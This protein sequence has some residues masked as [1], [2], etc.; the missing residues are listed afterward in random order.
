MQVTKDSPKQ[1][2]QRTEAGAESVVSSEKQEEQRELFQVRDQVEISKEGYVMQQAAMPQGKVLSLPKE[3]IPG[4]AAYKNA[5]K[6]AEI[7]EPLAARENTG[8]SIQ[9]RQT[10]AGIAQGK[11]ISP[12]AEKALRESNPSLYAQV[13]AKAKARA[14]KK[15]QPQPVTEEKTAE[16][17]PRRKATQNNKGI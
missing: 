16:K 5:K 7:R 9:I 11:K 15:K 12:A 14:G 2:A 1:A 6:T 17:T 3:T 8:D 13:K 4:K 10:A